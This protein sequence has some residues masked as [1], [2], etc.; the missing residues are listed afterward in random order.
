MIAG[1]PSANISPGA[2]RKGEKVLD[3][4]ISCTLAFTGV[5]TGEVFWS[6]MLTA[7]LLKF[8]TAIVDTPFIYLAVWIEKRTGRSEGDPE[9]GL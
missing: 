1:T 3:S 5:Y 9:T 8:V 4:V 7:Y 2:R 6:V